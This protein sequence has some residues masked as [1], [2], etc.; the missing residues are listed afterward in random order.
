[1]ADS[2][3]PGH[4]QRESI[5]TVLPTLAPCAAGSVVQRSSF[6]QWRTVRSAS[7]ATSRGAE[8]AVAVSNGREQLKSA[9]RTCGGV[10][11]SKDCVRGANE[12]GR[13]HGQQPRL[14]RT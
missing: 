12:P 6:C 8:P 1:M 13:V 11:E 3:R 2:Q 7:A 5:H 9:A 14:P 10:L 4:N